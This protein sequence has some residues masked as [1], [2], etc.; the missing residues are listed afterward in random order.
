MV[1]NAFTDPGSHLSGPAETWLEVSASSDLAETLLLVAVLRKALPGQEIELHPHA[2]RPPRLRTSLAASR[3][4]EILLR[5]PDS[6]PLTMRSLNTHRLQIKFGARTAAVSEMIARFEERQET[7]IE[8]WPLGSSDDVTRFVVFLRESLA[9]DD[10]ELRPSGNG[11]YRFC[12]DRPLPAVV[13]T[14]LNESHSQPLALVLVPAGEVRLLLLD[15]GAEPPAVQTD[16][17]TARRPPPSDGRQPGGA[18]DRSEAGLGIGAN[19]RRE[20]VTSRS[21]EPDVG[22]EA[23]PVPAQLTRATVAFTFGLDLS[24]EPPLRMSAAP[25]ESGTVPLAEDAGRPASEGPPVEPVA[26]VAA[27]PRPLEPE[28]TPETNRA[29]EQKEA[30]GIAQGAELL[31]DPTTGVLSWPAFSIFAAATISQTRRREGSLGILLVSIDD[32]ST[33]DEART[34]EDE[35]TVLRAVTGV[36]L[37]TVRGGDMVGRQRERTFVLLAQD[38][39]QPGAWRLAERIREAFPDHVDARSTATPLRLSIGVATLPHAGASVPELLQ[40]A[41][42]ALAEAVERGGNQ[43]RMCRA[44]AVITRN[45]GESR[46]SPSLSLLVADVNQPL[47]VQRRATL[48]QAT[49]AFD[50]GEAE[51]ITIQAQP[52]AC[53]VC[54]DAARD[55]YRPQ[56]APPLP[57]ANCTFPGDCRCVYDIPPPDL[58]QRPPP[59]AAANYPDLDIPR[60]FREA[61]LFGSG[62]KSG[63]RPEDLAEYLERFPLLPFTIGIDLQ[64]GEAAYLARPARRA[65]EHDRSAGLAEHGPLF[66]LRRSLLSWVKLVGKPPSAAGDVFSSREEGTVYLTNWRILFSGKAGVESMLLADV[67][68]VEYFRDAV[69]CVV[70]EQGNRTVFFLRDP[71]QVGLCFSR[72]VRDGQALM[73]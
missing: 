8:S 5:L 65:V 54:L 43:A 73:R 10:V 11:R 41:E 34:W 66:P 42:E 69:A 49:Q 12:L 6:V 59:L 62:P 50:R 48:L 45:E 64:P 31:R 22:T 30:R 56:W 67:T 71:L 53:P 9:L 19:Q 16:P 20:E 58:S 23:P 27:E 26:I 47:D 1:A 2:G 55:L 68:G 7:W 61:A 4:L 63:C 37:R 13:A 17:P 32:W 44:S 21:E 24:S 46:P 38:A 3:I 51:G 39:L 40:N 33:G 36:L 25:S 14:L 35:V 29:V 57:L 72:A 28:P 70:G 15:K 52:N 60:K 18:V